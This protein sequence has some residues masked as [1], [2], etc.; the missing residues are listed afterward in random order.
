M[1][2]IARVKVRV[3]VKQVRLG[4]NEFYFVEDCTNLDLFTFA[5]NVRNNYSSL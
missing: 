1:N 5:M 4:L 3:R 2:E